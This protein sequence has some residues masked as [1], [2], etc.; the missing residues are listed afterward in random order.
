MQPSETLFLKSLGKSIEK[1]VLSAKWQH[2]SPS[3][4]RQPHGV[5][6]LES[7]SVLALLAMSGLFCSCFKFVVCVTG[8]CIRTQLLESGLVPR[9]RFEPRLNLDFNLFLSSTARF[10]NLGFETL[11]S[12]GSLGN[13]RASGPLTQHNAQSGHAPH[14]LLRCSSAVRVLSQTRNGLRL[15]YTAPWT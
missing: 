11:V 9:E 14:L 4:G 1:D 13:P 8:S 15:Q 2:S 7:R 6:V 10:W 12:E 3:G 5:S